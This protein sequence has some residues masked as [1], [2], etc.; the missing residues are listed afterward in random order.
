MPTISKMRRPRHRSHA[1]NLPHVAR[2]TATDP[3]LEQ[4]QAAAVALS[5]DLASSQRKQLAVAGG[6]T[7]SRASRWAT[8]GK[9]N[10]LFD[11]TQMIFSL[12]G[13]GQHPGALVAHAHMAMEAA[14]MS[15][16]DAD[17]VRRFWEAMEREAHKEG[18]ENAVSQTFARSGDLET[19]RRVMLDEAAAQTELAALCLEME[20][21]GI[22]PRKD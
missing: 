12:T 14:L 15:V 9:G 17:L 7:V 21:R 5:L 20:R 11:F 2:G 13:T 8:E 1:T 6:V 16:S 18:A 4:V 19:L 3:R 10:P 22:D